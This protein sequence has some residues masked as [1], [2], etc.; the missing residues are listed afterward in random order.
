MTFLPLFPHP[1]DLHLETSSHDEIGS[2]WLE[3][4]L[5]HGGK[6]GLVWLNILEL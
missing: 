1:G 5:F 6:V 3:G 4:I 2:H